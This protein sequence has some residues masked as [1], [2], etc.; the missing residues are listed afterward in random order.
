M[1][2]LQRTA[3]RWKFSS[4]A[5]SVRSLSTRATHFLPLEESRDYVRTLNFPSVTSYRVWA[6]SG[7]RPSYIPSNPDRFYQ[8]DAGWTSF[9]DWLGLKRISNRKPAT[10]DLSVAGPEALRKSLYLRGNAERTNFVNRIMQQ[11]P[12]IEFLEL[13]RH[14]RASH[15]VRIRAGDH[16]ED[17]WFPIQIRYVGNGRLNDQEY[18]VARTADADT[19]VIIVAHTGKIVA[20]RASAMKTYFRA[21]DFEDADGVFEYLEDWWTHSQRLTESDWADRLSDPGMV[22]KTAGVHANAISALRA[23]YFRPLGFIFRTQLHVA[24]ILSGTVDGKYDV[25]VRTVTENNGQFRVT[26][27]DGRG[28]TPSALSADMDFDFLVCVFPSHLL[29]QELSSSSGPSPVFVFPK[30]ALGAWGILSNDNIHGRR[31]VYLHPPFRQ[32]SKIVKTSADWQRQQAPFYVTDLAEMTAVLRT[33]D[34]GVE[35]CDV[36]KTKKNVS[37]L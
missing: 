35:V 20:G 10:S 31:N 9:S 32:T 36:G 22:G 25:V 11:R 4:V 2:F 23:Q 17:C 3:S 37:L 26:V 12:D 13:R 1:L 18:A 8:K 14:L 19:P 15:L 6:R 24:G 27:H 7:A 33:A 28:P 21:G 29:P 5:C 30:S 34:T 16:Q